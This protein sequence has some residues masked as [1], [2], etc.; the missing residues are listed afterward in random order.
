MA[1]RYS[2][3]Q[4]LSLF[5]LSYAASVMVFFPDAAEPTELHD[6]APTPATVSK[7]KICG[8]NHSK[9]L[10]PKPSSRRATTIRIQHLH[11]LS[12]R[13]RIERA[14]LY[15]L[16]KGLGFQPGIPASQVT[17]RLPKIQVFCIMG[18]LV[19]LCRS[20]APMKFFACRTLLFWGS[21]LGL[22]ATIPGIQGCEGCRSKNRRQTPRAAQNNSNKLRSH[23]ARPPPQETR[24]Q[25]PARISR[26]LTP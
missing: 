1:K 11:P 21:A 8:S 17:R 2:I 18:R 13:T 22:M 14:A 4:S 3:L 26:L 25:C 7:A 24:E 12:P 23:R 6:T 20:W 15:P 5:A 9:L 16:R 10:S 19:H